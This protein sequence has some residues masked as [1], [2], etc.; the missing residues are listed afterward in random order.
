M[1]RTKKITLAAL[2]G[3]TALLICGS[4]LPVQASAPGF[5]TGKNL[6][7]YERIANSI[8][9]VFLGDTHGCG[10]NNM[11]ELAVRKLGFNEVG[12][13]Y[14]YN[15]EEHEFR[16]MLITCAAI[17]PV[18]TDI[19]AYHAY[20]YWM[21]DSGAQFIGED[22]VN[23]FRVMPESLQLVSNME[24]PLEKKSGR[25]V[26]GTGDWRLQ[27]SASE[28]FDKF[29]HD[30][31]SAG[32][33]IDNTDK[34]IYHTY[35]HTTNIDGHVDIPDHTTRDKDTMFVRLHVTKRSA[36]YNTRVR[37]T[38]QRFKATATLTIP[39]STFNKTVSVTSPYI[40]PYHTD[41]D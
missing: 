37:Y 28:T 36:Q 25:W 5:L 14:K 40:S 20:Y 29:D 35:N 3:G 33:K 31:P 6:A 27:D 11:D 8:D 10:N 15:G 39:N 2:A 9:S 4:A 12:G 23:H 34:T 16:G 30:W 38:E 32:F 26:A 1:R 19:R 41:W 21:V 24:V 22:Q 7:E 17:A 13:I 18:V